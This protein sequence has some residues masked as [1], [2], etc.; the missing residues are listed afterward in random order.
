M[1]KPLEVGDIVKITFWDH[2]ENASD[3]FLFDVYGMIS[4]KT[5]QALII[6][7]WRYHDPLD[8]A[9]DTRDDNENRFAIVKK[10]IQSIEVLKC[11]KPSKR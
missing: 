1:K 11:A 9:A 4:K 5:R 2:A 3:A 8:A 10:A 6:D 7:S